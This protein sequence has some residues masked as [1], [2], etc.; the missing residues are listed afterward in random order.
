MTYQELSIINSVLYELSP[1]NYG[2][3]W[4][5]FM[6]EHYPE[7]L[8]EMIENNTLLAVT[9]SVDDYAWE[10]RELLD[11]QYADLHPRPKEYW[12]VVAWERTRAFYTDSAVMRERVLI[13]YTKP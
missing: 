13:P 8:K 7:L 1:C 6:R 10:Y 11:N 5:K 9:K 12:E 4:I 3:K 2:E